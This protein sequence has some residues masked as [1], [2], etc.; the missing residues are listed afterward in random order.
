MLLSYKA[1]KL[2]ENQFTTGLNVNVTNDNKI[3]IEGVWQNSPA[4]KAKIKPGDIVLSFNSNKIN[5]DNL[6]DLQKLLKNDNVKTI[7]LE[8]QNGNSRREITLTKEMLF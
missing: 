1:N 4:D 5:P 2:T 6:G 8:L 7:T 3:Y